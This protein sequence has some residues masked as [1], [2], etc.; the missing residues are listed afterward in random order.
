MKIL[1]IM[2][3]KTDKGLCVLDIEITP[4]MM[5]DFEP[6]EIDE[7]NRVIEFIDEKYSNLFGLDRM[8]MIDKL[9]FTKDE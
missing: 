2:P 9:L 6:F 4:K 8:N 1:S 3:P 5:S 7:Y